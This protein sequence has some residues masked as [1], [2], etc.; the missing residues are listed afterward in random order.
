MILNGKSTNYIDAGTTLTQSVAIIEF[1]NDTHPSSGL[2]P[3]DPIT[4]AKVRMITEIICSGI[5]PIQARSSGDYNKF[6]NKHFPESFSDDLS[7]K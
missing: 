6:I 4:R 1:I 7:F 2:L 3:Q 5:Q